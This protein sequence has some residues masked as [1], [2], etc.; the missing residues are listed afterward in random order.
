[1]DLEV[2][3]NVMNMHSHIKLSFKVG[4]GGTFALRSVPGAFEMDE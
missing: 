2:T 4:T 1:M 3:V